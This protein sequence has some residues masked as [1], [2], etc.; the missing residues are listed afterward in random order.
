MARSRGGRGRLGGLGGGEIRGT[1]GTLLRTTLAQA[2]AVKDALERGAREGRARLD[3]ARLGRRHE[4]ALAQLGAAVLEHVRRGDLADLEEIREIADAIAAVEEVEARLDDRDEPAPPPP[5]RRRAAVAPARRDDRADGTVSSGSWAPPRPAASAK[6]WRP[7]APR[8][9]DQVEPPSNAHID[10]A[11]EPGAR[12]REDRRPRG[13]GITFARH[14][15]SGPDPDDDLAEYM[16][17]D[18]VPPPG[19][20]GKKQG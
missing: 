4:E 6:V 7:T 9:H 15:E 16:N 18:D 20:S 14:D 17:P 3:D 1:L 5:S 19:P 2:G 10:D 11:P 8:E 12:F 13:G